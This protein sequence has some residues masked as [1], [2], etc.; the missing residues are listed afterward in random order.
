MV[1]LGFPL[2]V[3]CRKINIIHKVSVGM[4]LV[5]FLHALNNNVKNLNYLRNLENIAKK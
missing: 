5:L 3:R 4:N 2:L 1:S